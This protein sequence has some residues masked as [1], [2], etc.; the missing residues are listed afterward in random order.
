MQF[1]LFVSSGIA[2][3]ILEALLGLTA[4][5]SLQ[6]CPVHQEG[7][8]SWLR[9]GKATFPPYARNARDGVIVGGSYEQYLS[10]YLSKSFLQYNC[11]TA[12]T[13]KS[14]KFH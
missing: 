1:N 8:W 13:T 3:V 14:A 9:E 10:M 11:F 7:T 6:C 5:L 12:M 2:V 4:D